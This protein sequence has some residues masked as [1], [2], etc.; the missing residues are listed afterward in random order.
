MLE[1]ASSVEVVTSC[2]IPAAAV[3]RHLGVDVIIENFCCAQATD[4]LATFWQRDGQVP[5]ATIRLGESHSQGCACGTTYAH[6][7]Q[8]VADQ[9]PPLQDGNGLSFPA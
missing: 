2:N 3:C 6:L 8:L 1:E 4:Q 5:S 9:D 7:N